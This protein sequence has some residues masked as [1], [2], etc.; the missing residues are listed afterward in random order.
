M[1]GF[2][3]LHRIARAAERALKH[4]D[5]DEFAQPAID[6]LRPLIGLGP[7]AD[8]TRAE[9]DDVIGQP[10]SIRSWNRSQQQLLEALL[11]Q[12][13]SPGLNFGAIELFLRVDGIR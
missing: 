7:D 2:R 1:R 4:G 10:D 9:I 8:L 12:M 6:C 5:P 3:A 11:E 13:S